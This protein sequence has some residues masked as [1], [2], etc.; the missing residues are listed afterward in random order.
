LPIPGPALGLSSVD[1]WHYRRPPLLGE[2]TAQVLAELLG[3]T[4][5]EVAELEASGVSGRTLA[6][7]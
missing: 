5:A 7:S 1:R 2:H 3:M 4:P 6:G